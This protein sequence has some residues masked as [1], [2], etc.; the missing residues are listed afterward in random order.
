[1]TDFARDENRQ[2]MARAIEEVRRK[3]G[4][5]YPL[6][7]AGEEIRTE[8][9]HLDSLDPS[10]SSRVVGRTAMA[11]AEHAERAVG[12]GAEDPCGLGRADPRANGPGS[13]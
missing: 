4:Q 7:I 2:A 11:G 3:L 8:G 12:R 5:T 6:L 9:R 10:Q 13:C 1:M